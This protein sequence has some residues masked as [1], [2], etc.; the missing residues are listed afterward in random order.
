MKKMTIPMLLLII[1][2]GSAFASYQKRGKIIRTEEGWYLIPSDVN[3]SSEDKKRFLNLAKEVGDDFG[4]LAYKDD[5]GLLQIQGSA[6]LTEFRTVGRIMK[7][8]LEPT[9]A[10]SLSGWIFRNE[11]WD[12]NK[13]VKKTL[14]GTEKAKAALE[15]LKPLLEKYS[16]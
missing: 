4:S 15:R 10:S 5:N 7:V 12:D 9:K 2:V 16:R 13:F 6:C 3:I 14:A 8:N 11:K 1:T